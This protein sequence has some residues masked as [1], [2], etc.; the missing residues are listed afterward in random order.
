MRYI[1]G[2]CLF[3][4]MQI[5]YGQEIT[6]EDRNLIQENG[7]VLFGVYPKDLEDK[8]QSYGVTILD[9]RLDK[10]ENNYFISA[11]LQS[12]EILQINLKGCEIEHTPTY[13]AS[14]VIRV[15]VNSE[16]SNERLQELLLTFWRYRLFNLGENIIF[17][18]FIDFS[19]V[20]EN[21]IDFRI[22]EL[23]RLTDELVM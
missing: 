23:I 14:A 15:L 21:Y 10:T 3:F 19:D 2:V 16:V 20:S 5:A 17:S 22:E 6:E 8:L 12:S 9:S 11:S 18:S 7:S 1:I 4:L 13:C